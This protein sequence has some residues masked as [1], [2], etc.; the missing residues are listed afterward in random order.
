MSIV[1]SYCLKVLYVLLS[2][3][4]I[5]GWRLGIYWFLEKAINKIIINN[6]TQLSRT[7]KRWRDREYLHAN[8]GSVSSLDQSSHLP[9]EVLVRK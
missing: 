8:R 4:T 1:Y 6:F 9:S 5:H 3:Q 7:S 2:N